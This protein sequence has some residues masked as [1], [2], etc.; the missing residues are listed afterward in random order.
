MQTFVLQG[1]DKSFHVSI[2]CRRPDAAVPMFDSVMSDYL[3]EPFGEFRAMIG[4]NGR[5]L[6]RR[7]LVSL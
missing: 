2:V 6:K 4:L 3:G 5:E 7:M 1:A